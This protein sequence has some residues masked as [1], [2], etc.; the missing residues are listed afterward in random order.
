MP[1]DGRIAKLERAL[2]SG[3]REGGS[4]CDRCGQDGDPLGGRPEAEVLAEAKRRSERQPFVSE[5]FPQTSPCLTCG[6]PRVIVFEVV[7]NWRE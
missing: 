7:E 1:L 3:G 5:A 4:P 6:R 2:G